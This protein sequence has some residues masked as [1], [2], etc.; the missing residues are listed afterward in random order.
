MRKQLIIIP[1]LALLFSACAP[2]SI[3]RLNPTTDQGVW[4]Y[5]Q[6]FLFDTTSDINVYIAFDREYNDCHA[7][8]VEIVNRGETSFLVDPAQ[9][10]V[11]TQPINTAKFQPESFT[12]IDPELRLLA[13]D[14]AISRSQAQAANASI[15][16]A[17]VLG[18]GMVAIASDAHHNRPIEKA[19]LHANMAIA[20]A[21]VAAISSDVATVQSYDLSY[22][23]QTWENQT[24]RKTTLAPNM[25]IQGIV[26]IPKKLNALDYIITIPVRGKEVQFTFRQNIIRAT[27]PNDPAAGMP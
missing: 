20:G 4:L 27:T 2:R 25:S 22:N 24:I 26:F 13:M 16:A 9:I 21:E 7:F 19:E 6:Q 8:S 11:L 17:V 1:L 23:K 10:N 5:G 15:I 18:A 3:I 14:K 12:A